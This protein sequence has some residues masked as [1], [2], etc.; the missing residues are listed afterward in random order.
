L[1]TVIK[2][3]NSKG[4]RREVNAVGGLDTVD[5][6]APD[7]NQMELDERPRF[8]IKATN[9]TAAIKPHP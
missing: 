4:M 2:K 6:P 3:Q 7:S 1:T 9:S 5:F 8:Q